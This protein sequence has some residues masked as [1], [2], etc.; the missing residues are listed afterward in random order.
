[1]ERVVKI[2]CQ[3]ERKEETEHCFFPAALH[4][5]C[6][7]KTVP[8]AVDSSEHVL[9]LDVVY[10]I[11]RLNVFPLRLLRSPEPSTDMNDV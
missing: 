6:P 8:R 7:L 3:V 4:G 5:V 11:Q 2:G 10:C 1:M 9:D